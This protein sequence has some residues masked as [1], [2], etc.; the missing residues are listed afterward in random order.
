MYDDYYEECFNNPKVSAAVKTIILI[1][2][3]IQMYL[4]VAFH[5]TAIIKS[6]LKEKKVYHRKINKNDEFVH[7]FNLSNTN[8]VKFFVHDDFYFNSMLIFNTFKNKYFNITYLNYTFSSKFSKVKLEFIF[9][10]YDKNKILIHPSDFTLYNQMSVSCFMIINDTKI[11]SL[12]HIIDDK[13][14]KCI[15]FFNID[16]NAKFG[17]HFNPQ[18]SKSFLRI[19]FD[20]YKYV[21]LTDSFHKNDTIFDPTFINDEYNKLVE[22]TKNKETRKNYV[23]KRNY[24]KTPFV[25]LKRAVHNVS[26]KGGWI[27][28]N[29]YNN[30]FCY[31]VGET[32]TKGEVRQ[33]CK[34][35]FYKHVIDVNRDLYPKTHHIF[36]D[37]IFKSLPSDDTYP[38]FEEMIKQNLSAHYITEKPQL[39]KMYCQNDP[40]CQTILFMNMKQYFKFGEF[41]EK[42]LTLILQLKSV[43][44]CKQSSF[45]YLSYLFYKTEYITYIAVGHGVDFFKDYLFLPYRIYGSKI[46][47]KILIPPS[48]VLVDLAVRRGWKE[49][50]IIQINLPRWDRFSKVDHFFPGNVT[51]NSIL[52][53]FTWRYTKWWLGFSNLSKMYH[54]NIIK[55]LEDE[56]L[57]KALS[58]KNMILYFSLHR[59]VNRRF[60]KRYDDAINKHSYLKYLRQNELSECLAKTNLVVS[61]FSSI[62]FDLMSRNK[63]FIMYVPDE[64]DKQIS[65]IYTND[66]VNLIKK[67]KS[68]KIVFKNKCNSLKATVKKIIKY[69][70]NGFKLEPELKKFYKGFNFKTT[71]NTNEFIDYIMNLK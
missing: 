62:I 34:L 71:N 16:E 18:R 5:E 19:N 50:N 69:I 38:I 64:E 33:M 44:S 67:M 35:N 4:F 39:Q 2:L 51:S 20:F 31:C 41:V 70:N 10:I 61:D 11:Y 29:I 56:K 3:L 63:P 26:K 66:Y 8:M 1:N 47:N 65:K 43:V 6:Q 40:K 54:E 58:K 55:L 22:I 59:L 23:L 45:H 30:Y 13:Y 68:G 15:E 7:D 32:C 52:V 37:F 25:E 9:G 36:V 46:N 49:E 21:N 53:M 27:F 48:E 24:M 42:Y 17:L 14:Y 60:L 57:G 12:P 28:R